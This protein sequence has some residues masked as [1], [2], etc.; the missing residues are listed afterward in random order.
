MTDDERHHDPN[1]AQGASTLI[2]AIDAA[3]AAGYTTTFVA[4]ATGD[5]TC[6]NCHRL[7]NPAALKVDHV[8]RLEGAS[9]A[10]DLMLVASAVCPSCGAAG[11]LSLGYGPNAGDGDIAVLPFLDLTHA[12]ASPDDR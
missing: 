7:V 9:D 11:V 1:V 12:D 2:E 6:G 3:A 4:N 5:V 10:A 8:R